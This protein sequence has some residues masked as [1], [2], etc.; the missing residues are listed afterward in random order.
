MW[1]LG[2]RERDVT[3]RAGSVGRFA[4]KHGIEMDFT[5]VQANP[6]MN[7]HERRR[8]PSRHYIV[9][10]IKGD[11]EYS[12]P[13]SMGFGIAGPPTLTEVLASVAHD[14]LDLENHGRNFLDFADEMSIDPTDRWE[15]KHFMDYVQMM[16][17]F[18]A[19]LGPEAYRELL[20]DVPEVQER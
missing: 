6:T 3:F 12:I 9:R 18:K 14:A 20:H 17:D 5:P 1:I 19:F 2:V 15:Q 4:K 7:P 11:K 8:F 16:D 13:F 10:F